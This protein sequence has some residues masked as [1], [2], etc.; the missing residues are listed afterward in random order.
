MLYALLL[1]ALPAAAQERKIATLPEYVEAKDVVFSPDGSS[2]AFPAKRGGGW[3]A[4]VGD[5][6]G[7]VWWRV[8]P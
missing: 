2:I 4:V 6:E 8:L 5:K 7:E 1:L 3:H